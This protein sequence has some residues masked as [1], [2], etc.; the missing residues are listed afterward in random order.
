[1]NETIIKKLCQKWLRLSEDER[2]KVRSVRARQGIS[3][4][5]CG[6]IGYFTQICP[7]QTPSSTEVATSKSGNPPVAVFWGSSNQIKT[8]D[9]GEASILAKKEKERLEVT[10][11]KARSYDYFQNVGESY[12][13][14]IA[15]LTLFQV[16]RKLIRYVHELLLKNAV[17]L[18]SKYDRTIL[19]PPD[20]A[21]D[22]KG[23][24]KA[25]MMYRDYQPFLY[26]KEAKQEVA[27]KGKASKQ[28]TA[29]K[30]CNGSIYSNSGWRSTISI[31]DSDALS[32]AEPRSSSLPP[33]RATWHSL[34][35]ERMRHHNDGFEHLVH[36][37]GCEL[38]SEHL[39][40]GR[41]LTC[42][43]SE[44]SAIESKIWCERFDAADRIIQTMLIYKISSEAEDWDYFVY[45]LKQW[46]GMNRKHR[47]RRKAVGSDVTRPRR[48]GDGSSVGDQSLSLVSSQ[49]D[50]VSENDASS[51]I[52][53]I[54]GE[55]I[56]DSSSIVS[57][58]TIADQTLSSSSTTATRGRNADET[59]QHRNE[60]LS[61]LNAKKKSQFM[62][63]IIT[64]K[65][66]IIRYLS[67]I[68]VPLVMQSCG[69]M[70]SKGQKSCIDMNFLP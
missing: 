66:R 47:R 35:A 62:C 53:S 14:N 28:L 41:L 59:V 4:G 17:H 10:D 54:N 33:P 56:L 13:S 45:G 38:K 43:S 44:R 37:V 7:C 39:R 6:K 18:E 42:P 46:K 22:E 40:E 67:Y 27:Q 70:S 50:S 24:R 21:F 60:R 58:S 36:I 8:V 3:C 32:L 23:A 65:F 63:V 11:K 34:Q 20:N 57:S 52:S 31:D 25:L 61:R 64:I 2:A 30:A 5:I 48:E 12:H 15:D 29:E 1:M 16:L 55:S 26:K 9:I 19:M 69:I 51:L 68:N 49:F